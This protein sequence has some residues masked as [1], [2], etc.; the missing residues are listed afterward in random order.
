[1]TVVFKCLETDTDTLR[2]LGMM[3]SFNSTTPTDGVFIRKNA[4]LGVWQ[5][6]T[7]AS[8]SETVS[9]TNLWTQDTNWHKIKIV[10]NGSTVEFYVDGA[11]S[12]TTTISTNIPS[13]SV[14]MYPVYMNQPTVG[15]LV[16]RN[17]IDFWSFKLNG[18]TR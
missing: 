15:S 2:I 9:G 6:V 4:A 11:G 14:I 5:A 12:P 1:M 8:S 16:R 17:Q 18:P 3:S 10:K 13:S 7:R